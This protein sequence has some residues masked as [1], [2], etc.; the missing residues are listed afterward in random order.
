MMHRTVCAH[1]PGT[2]GV[3]PEEYKQKRYIFKIMLNTHLCYVTIPNS[4]MCGHMYMYR[5]KNQDQR[6]VH[7][8]SCETNAKF[9]F[10]YFI[11]FLLFTVILLL[12]AIFQ[13]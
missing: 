9:T 2:S 3:K 11:I 5:E 1:V 7:H 6:E 12:S 13:N 8:S 4:F 10:V